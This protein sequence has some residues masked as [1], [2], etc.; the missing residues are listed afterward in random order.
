MKTKR[1]INRTKTKRKINRTKTKRMKG[2]SNI[3]EVIGKL[4]AIKDFM[5]SLPSDMPELQVVDAIQKTFGEL[6][7]VKEAVS[8]YPTVVEHLSNLELLL[9]L[10]DDKYSGK[11]AQED[12]TTYQQKERYP[13]GC[14]DAQLDWLTGFL[15]GPDLGI[16]EHNKNSRISL[17]I[18][19]KID[20]VKEF[21]KTSPS[22]TEYEFKCNIEAVLSEITKDYDI[23][24]AMKK[25]IIH[26][27]EIRDLF[28]ATA[29]DYFEDGLF[30]DGETPIPP[31]LQSTESPIEITTV[32]LTLL[33]GGS[34]L[35]RSDNTLIGIVRFDHHYARWISVDLVNGTHEMVQL[36]PGMKYR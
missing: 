2:G 4:R 21:L 24:M 25:G 8:R 32:P 13:S 7:H 28:L 16:T 6:L 11:D 1:K 15:I 29:R 22:R 34:Q 33:P 10:F 5:K 23:M 14:L 27:D 31:V 3:L 17:V 30:N 26:S 36:V 9:Q 20:A 12:S 35:F 19:R 18:Q